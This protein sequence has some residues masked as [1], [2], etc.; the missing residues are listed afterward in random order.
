M[1]YD[2]KVYESP[3]IEIEEV[4]GSELAADFNP[5]DACVVIGAVI[6]GGAIVIAAVID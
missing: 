1:D 2:V 4:E 5:A 6:T 3:T